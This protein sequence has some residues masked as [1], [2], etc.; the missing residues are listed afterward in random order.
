MGK[1]LDDFEDKMNY[2]D[3]ALD[4]DDNDKIDIFKFFSKEKLENI[5]RNLSKATGLAFVTVD[6][7]GEP[8]TESTLFTKFCSEVRKSDSARERCKSSDA[9]GSIQ[10]AVS[11]TTSVY[12]CP[13]G[14]LEVAIPIIVKDQYLGGF[15]GGQVRCFDAPEN[16]NSLQTVVRNEEAEAFSSKCNTL[17]E[18]VSVVEYEKF[19]NIANLVSMV[20]NELVDNALAQHKNEEYY[21]KYINKLK[22]LNLNHIEEHKTKDM[23]LQ[24]LKLLN[25]PYMI[26]DMLNSVLNLN[27][28]ENATSSAE[29]LES[30]IEFYK[31]TYTQKDTFVSVFSELEY[32]KKY[33]GLQKAKYSNR[34]EFSIK[35]PSSMNMKKVPSKVLLPFVKNAVYNSILLK[36]EGGKITISA[37]SINNN[38][39]FE[40]YD[41]GLSLNQ[42]EVEEKFSVFNENHDRFFIQL[43]MDYAKDKM[44]N[45]YGKNHRID[46]EKFEDIGQK[47]VIYWP[48]F[49]DERMK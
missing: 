46:I 13:C 41:N 24:E 16:V 7:R 4:L 9:F 45:I 49:Y 32:I 1:T 2:I 14:L 40:I 8:I 38:I 6:F 17:L 5:Q 22:T 21:K 26:V 11:K 23:Q 18:E 12:F 20:I 27:I 36:D 37:E 25:N 30:L 31:H 33:L 28:I 10:A 47:C 15:I 43:G 48:E 39:V 42:K 29:V 34:I 3:D 44:K 19:I 35:V